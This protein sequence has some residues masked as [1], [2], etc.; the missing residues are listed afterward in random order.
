MPTEK[1]TADELR[2]FTGS[3]TWYRHGLN[4]QILYTDGAQ[5]LAERAGAFWLLDEIALANAHIPAVKAE[6]FQL[7]TLTRNQTG[8]GAELTCEDGNNR[9]V[10]AKRIPFT[11]FPL[12]SVQLYCE[13]G[14]IL[15]PSEH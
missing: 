10:Y 14:T 15:L 2:Q 3:E 9:R 11:D 13:D 1:L 6:E 12:D 5:Y 8:N 7:W 4:P